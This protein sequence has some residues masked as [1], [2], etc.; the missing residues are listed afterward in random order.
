M[1]HA[2]FYDLV[3]MVV[4]ELGSIC[5]LSEEDVLGVADRVS[6]PGFALAG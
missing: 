3:A 4:T 6:K 5:R 1:N 2:S